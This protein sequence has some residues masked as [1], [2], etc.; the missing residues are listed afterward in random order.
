MWGIYVYTYILVYFHEFHFRYNR[1]HG[2]FGMQTTHTILFEV[3]RLVYLRKWVTSLLLKSFLS[4]V[5]GRTSGDST[6][7]S[8]AN[9]SLDKDDQSEV[10]EWCVNIRKRGGG[11][12]IFY[13]HPENWGRWTQFDEHIF[14]RGWFNHQL[15]KA[16]NLNFPFDDPDAPT[17]KVWTCNLKMLHGVSKAEISFFQALVLFNDSTARV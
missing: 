17:T 4:L 9:L 14:Q 3:Y 8:K 12:S 2:L 5:G 13:F 1:S 16:T 6:W 15:F 7:L 10:D 11:N